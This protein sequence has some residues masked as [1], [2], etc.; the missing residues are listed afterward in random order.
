MFGVNNSNRIK[1]K[2]SSIVISSMVLFASSFF[3]NKYN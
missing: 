3:K 2:F 1:I